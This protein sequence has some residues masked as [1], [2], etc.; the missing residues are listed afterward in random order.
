MAPLQESS[1]V[2]SSFTN[3]ASPPA[4]RIRAS[5]ARPSSSR[6]SPSTTLAPSAANSS[7]SQAP[8]PLA[9]PLM[10]ATLPWSLGSLSCMP[11]LEWDRYYSPGYSNSQR[12]P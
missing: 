3:R 7:P 11:L 6:M 12:E 2:T 9:P 1:L 8:I 10:N 5:V 4:E